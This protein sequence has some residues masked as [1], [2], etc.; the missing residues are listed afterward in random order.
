MAGTPLHLRAGGGQ[1]THLAYPPRPAE[2][3]LIPGKRPRAGGRADMSTPC[4]LIPGNRTT[5]GKNCEISTHTAFR[6]FHRVRG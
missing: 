6:S 4:V 3:V 1:D 5:G 2:T